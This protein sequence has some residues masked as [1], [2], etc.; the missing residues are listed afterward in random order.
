MEDSNN[1]LFYC[2]LSRFHRLYDR[3]LRSRLAPYDVNPGYLAVLQHL[4]LADDVTQTELKG[5]L[6]VE[7][8]TLSNTLRRMERD[9]LILRTPN[10]EDRRHHAIT[11]TEKGRTSHRLVVEAIEDLRRTVHQGLTVNDRRYFKRIMRQMTDQLED[12]LTEP[13]FV[14]LDEVTE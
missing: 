10:P 6:D 12:D 8:A 5:Q 1:D 2:Q 4:W 13:L 14:L 3:A 9:G 7:Q 11:L